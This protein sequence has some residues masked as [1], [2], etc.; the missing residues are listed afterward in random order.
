MQFN[1]VVSTNECAVRLWQSVGFAIVGRLALAFR[2]HT[3]G[4]VDGFVMYK[5]L[6]A[7]G[8]FC[9]FAMVR[10]DAPFG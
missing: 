9:H 10:F 3:G 6:G 8:R 5:V 1:F 2:R 4:Y 7:N